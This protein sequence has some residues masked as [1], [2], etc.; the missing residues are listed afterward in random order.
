V[1]HSTYL[2][3]PDS[4]GCLLLQYVDLILAEPT[5]GCWCYKYTMALICYAKRYSIDSV[6]ELLDLYVVLNVLTMHF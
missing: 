3:I 4:C 6:N 5:H 2:L 1:S